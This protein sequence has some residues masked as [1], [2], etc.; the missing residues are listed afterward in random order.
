MFE[1]QIMWRWKLIGIVQ[2]TFAFS[3]DLIH[4]GE[5]F[6]QFQHDLSNHSNLTDYRGQFTMLDI[7]ACICTTQFNVIF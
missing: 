7:V 2:E 3:L 5:I 4:T 6:V 1:D